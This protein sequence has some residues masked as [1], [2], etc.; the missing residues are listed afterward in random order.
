M[1][2]LDQLKAAINNGDLETAYK[3]LRR[4]GVIVSDKDFN[5]GSVP[6][7]QVGIIRH[8]RKFSISLRRGEVTG[9]CF[10]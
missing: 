5:I 1:L 10:A 3:D 4:Y 6:V 2:N 8:E 9:I 7:R